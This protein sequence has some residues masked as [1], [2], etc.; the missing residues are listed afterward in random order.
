MTAADGVIHVPVM[1]KEVLDHLNL[2]K[3]GIYVDGTF[4][5]GGHSQAI[6]K[7]LEK[8]RLIA[9]E[10]DK[11]FSDLTQKDKIFFAPCFCLINDNF[12]NLEE[13]LKKMGIQEVDGFLF[14]LGL[15][16]DQ[17]TVTERGFSYRSDSP[18]DMRIS[19][20]T[21]LS[22]TDI[23]NNYPEAKLADIFYHYGEEKK[24]RPIARKIC[25]WRKK[26]KIVNSQ[27]LV[28]IVASCF[29]HKSNK[30]PARKVFQALRIFVNSEL[31]NLSQ[32]LEVALK[33]LAIDGRIIVISY[34]SLEDRI[35]KQI[36]RK[37]SGLNFQIITKKPL[38]PAPQEVQENHRSRS[39]KM[40]VIR[41]KE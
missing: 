29:S 6:L 34:H 8:G 12:A 9:F 37:H 24:A 27:Q 16:S 21:K 28:G 1:L 15:S 40:R 35:V 36:F 31:E 19:Q 4:G 11:E 38:T 32:A 17:L 25:Y 13:H 10:W 23:I 14:D 7:N 3:G 2:K 33:Y 30:H 26:E 20:T 5:Q 41:R 22:A 39:A 18:L